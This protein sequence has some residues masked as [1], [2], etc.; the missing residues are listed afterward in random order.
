MD[1][2]VDIAITVINFD[3]GVI[4]LSQQFQKVVIYL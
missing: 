3:E 4:S 2:L 1:F